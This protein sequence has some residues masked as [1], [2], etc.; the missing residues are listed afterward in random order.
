V[1]FFAAADRLYRLVPGASPTDQEWRVQT[2]IE[3]KGES[4][5]PV[6]M[7]ANDAWLLVTREDEPLRI[8]DA[9]TLEEKQMIMTERGIIPLR[10]IAWRNLFLVLTSDGKIHQIKPNPLGDRHAVWTWSVVEDVEAMGLDA[11]GDRLWVAHHVDQLDVFEYGDNDTVVRSEQLRPRFKAWRWIDRYVVSALRILI[12]QTGELGQTTSVIVSGK[13][14][15]TLGDPAG[16]V[17]SQTVRLKILR[18][19]LSCM[20]FTIAMLTVSCFY[21]ATRDY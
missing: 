19:V 2:T 4:A 3:L 11:P 10:A 15:V 21:F 1:I 20:L 18:P 9:I 6:V 12:P 8:L 7:A 14:S 5:K 17:E 13:S 16:D